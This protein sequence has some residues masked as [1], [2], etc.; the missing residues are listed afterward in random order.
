[1]ISLFKKEKQ[2]L[3][4][5]DQNLSTRFTQHSSGKLSNISIKRLC[6][7]ICLIDIWFWLTGYRRD[8]EGRVH[9]QRLPRGLLP[10]RGKQAWQSYLPHW[11][12]Y[13]LKS[14]CSLSSK[15]HRLLLSRLWFFALS[16]QYRYWSWC[17]I[18]LFLMRTANWLPW[19][20]S[21]NF[22]PQ[23]LREPTGVS[24]FIL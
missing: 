13:Y 24:N 1:M 16:M 9:G 8:C 18:L 5:L 19:W 15:A 10:L 11:K 12:L 22:S 21:L 4:A 17:M 3:P 14:K 23:R 6:W 20:N 7:F 2:Q